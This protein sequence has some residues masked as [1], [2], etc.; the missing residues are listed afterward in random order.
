MKLRII[1]FDLA[2][3]YAILGMF[4]VNFNTVFGS[5]TD[6]TI[7]GQ[8]LSL[9]SGNSSSTFVILAGM[10]ISLMT[11]RSEYSLSEKA[12][13]KKIISRRSWFLFVIGLLLYLWWPADILHY[14]G[15]YMHLALLILFTHKKYYLWFAFLAIIIFHILFAVIPY[16]TGWNFNTLE[17]KDFWTVNGFL[18]N[19]LYN[20]WN[21]IF[22]WVAYF[23]AGM[24]LGRLDWRVYALQRKM[25]LLGLGL[26]IFIIALQFWATNITINKDLL[27]YISADYV[28]PFLPF[29][30]STFGFALMVIS[31]FMFLG[32]KFENNNYAKL[33]ASTGQ[34]TLTHYISHLTIGMIIFAFITGKKYTGHLSENAATS[35][36]LILLFAVS[37]FVLSCLLSQ[38]WARRFKNGPIE[39]LMRK[40]SG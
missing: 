15:G 37:Y 32:G 38:L 5:F 34:M 33:F 28:P 18:R 16:E 31:T 8:F 6:K 10:G 9:F 1:G 17:Y 25:F 22:P 29:M 7:V 23:F 40:I 2:R 14:Y 20:G 36:I 24:W 30:L 4:I 3:A 13:L 27:M 11:N 19:T 21:S 12:K 35:P 26:L 39:T